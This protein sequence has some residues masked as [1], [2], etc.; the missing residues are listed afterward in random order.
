MSWGQAFWSTQSHQT[1]HGERGFM[2]WDPKKNY[3]KST[4]ILHQ[5]ENHLVFLLTCICKVIRTNLDAHSYA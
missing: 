5:N 1:P 3:I 4:H 2:V